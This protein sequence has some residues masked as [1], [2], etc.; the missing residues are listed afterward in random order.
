MR[1]NGRRLT[2]DSLRFVFVVWFKLQWTLF[3]MLVR[4]ACYTLVPEQNGQDFVDDSFTFTFFI[5]K[6]IF[7]QL[8]PMILSKQLVSIDSGAKPL[9]QPM[10]T[11][12]TGVY[13]RHKVLE[14]WLLTHIWRIYASLELNEL[15]W[16][17]IS[18]IKEVMTS[19]PGGAYMHHWTGSSLFQVGCHAV[20]WTNADLLSSAP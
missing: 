20:T 1:Q 8:S 11:L 13:M 3:L 12:F 14:G 15:M 4:V 9:P 5:E 7:I 2:D 6:W 18:C 17:V 19:R 16:S 10:V